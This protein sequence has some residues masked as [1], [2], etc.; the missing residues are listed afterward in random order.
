MIS[1]LIAAL[2][3]VIWLYLIGARG[4]FW[5]VVPASVSSLGPAPA[6]RIAVIVPARN[7]A[8]VIAQAVLSLL[9][10]DYPGPLHIFVVDD[11]SSDG[12]GELARN[13]S[14]AKPESLTV[15][16]AAPLPSGWTGK[17]W[18]LAQGVEH[19]A[20]FAPDYFLFT[21]ADIVHG[22]ESIRSSVA[23]AQA[24]NRDLVSFM[25][26]LRCESVAEQALIPAFVFFFFLLYPPEWVNRD[27][28]RTAA[29]AG[30]DIL[31]RAE[32]LARIGG[33]ST[34]RNELIDDCALAREVKRGGMVSLGLTEHARS[35]RPYGTFAVIGRMISRTAFY[36]LRHSVWLLIATFLGLGIT[37][38]APPVLVFFGGWAA[39][40]AGVAWLLMTISYWP[41]VRYYRVSALWAAMLPLIAG[42]YALATMHSA[43][44]YWTGRGGEWKD[45]VQDTRPA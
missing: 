30:G 4:K 25:V 41:M 23:L 19:S 18:A 7:E 20:D 1:L 5:Q 9:Q 33:I 29:A 6:P 39:L 35:I 36:Q 32:A 26:K 24:G 22:P 34:I 43:I 28:R 8:E 13:A 12:T 44:Q 17:M 37:Y 2:S 38:L 45:R 16:S 10:Q 14:A 11:H 27:E 3:C 21:D 15:V 42:F 40:F 31:V